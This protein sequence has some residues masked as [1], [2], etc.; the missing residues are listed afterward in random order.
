MNKLTTSLTLISALLLAGTT[1]AAQVNFTGKVTSQTCQFSNL[2]GGDSLLVPLLDVSQGALT[3]AG[4]TAGEKTF[5]IKLSGCTTNDNVYID[6]GTANAD[7]AAAGTLKN[8]AA[9]AGAAQNVNIQLLKIAGTA[10]NPVNLLA[11]TASDVKK[12]SAGQGEYVFNYAARYYAT[13]ESKAGLV[14]S[15]ATITIKYQ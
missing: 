4:Q 15:N 9:A 1:Q 14:A 12:V 7:S 6:F 3:A 5:D 10:K 11:Q 8:I 13:G 2:E